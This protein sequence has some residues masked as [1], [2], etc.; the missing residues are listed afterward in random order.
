MEG[1]KMLNELVTDKQEVRQMV[2]ED[3]VNKCNQILIDGKK[4]SD[5][6][7][8][9]FVEHAATMNGDERAMS[10][11]NLIKA[12]LHAD[13]IQRIMACA[14]RG[15]VDA[16]HLFGEVRLLT[17]A[18]IKL[19][20]DSALREI[21]DPDFEF[22]FVNDKGITALVK[23]KKLKC[24]NV[25]QV[26]NYKTGAIS[27]KAQREN[28]RKL[29]NAMKKS[30]NSVDVNIISALPLDNGNIEFRCKMNGDD[31]IT[32]MVFSIGHLRKFLT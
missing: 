20:S 30:G 2:R 25:S 8:K 26:W 4:N 29:F 6:S 22:S 24:N 16:E 10:T 27:D 15:I 5:A 3:Y 23:A 14:A 17:H 32:A 11:R 12:G 9:K 19:A 18:T 28:R 7:V 31:N 1:E 21:S 13:R